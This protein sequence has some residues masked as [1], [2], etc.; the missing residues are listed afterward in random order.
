MRKLSSVKKR[1]VAVFFNVRKVAEHVLLERQKAVAMTSHGT[2]G[3]MCPEFKCSE[4]LVYSQRSTRSFSTTTM[5]LVC[6]T[7]A[8]IIWQVLGTR[9]WNIPP[10]QSRPPDF[11]LFLHMKSRAKGR[12]LP[13][14]E[15]PLRRCNCD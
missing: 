6:A 11:A 3:S 8:L 2:L 1:M 10:L 12:C 4:T 5:T 7:P 9:W 13:S 14:V 15:G